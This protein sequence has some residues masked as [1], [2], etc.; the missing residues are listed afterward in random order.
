ML[1]GA[2]PLGLAQATAN[3]R[4]FL[5]TDDDA[6]K[7]TTVVR[8]VD[9]SDGRARWAQRRWERERESTDITTGPIVID[10]TVY[11]AN[12]TG[13]ASQ[14]Y[15]EQVA[16]Q[17]EFPEATDK[18]IGQY[19]FPIKP[20]G[21]QIS[22][23]SACDDCLANVN[24]LLHHRIVIR[25]GPVVS[26]QYLYGT[27]AVTTQD[28][29]GWFAIQSLGHIPDGV[30]MASA[31]GPS[32]GAGS[33]G[34][35]SGSEQAPQPAASAAPSPQAAA[36]S[37]GVQA[38]PSDLAIAL[39]EAGKGA[40]KKAEADGSDA[41]G[42]W[43]EVR[44]ERDR[45]FGGYRSGPVTVYNRVFV[46]PNVEAARQIHGE[47]VCQNDKFPEA[48]E[49][50]GDV[51]EL[52]GVGEVGPDARGLSA[53]TGSCNTNK[54]VNVHKRIVSR[55]DNVVSV[56]YLWGL[57]DPEGTTDWHARY[58]ASLVDARARS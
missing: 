23:L 42:A 17:G 50:V 2:P 56:V 36:S 12:D 29:A 33:S 46:A 57:S 38:R 49:K 58:F 10:N 54:D 43:Y 11:V 1:V 24:L 15:N 39:G 34:P 13:V 48:K 3:P 19:E 52:K 28:L 30:P 26:V 6:G 44:Y 20:A 55:V 35:G 22:A 41:R 16:K 32:Q 37:A 8:D 14:I 53:C 9:D 18:R 51:F 5:L 21:V 25:K 7:H 4:D 27:E 31:P 45:D 47:Q 40:E